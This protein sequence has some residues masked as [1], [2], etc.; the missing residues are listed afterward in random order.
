METSRFLAV[1]ITWNP[2]GWRNNNYINPKAGHVHAKNNVG[3][4]ALNFK[5]NKITI[6]TNKFIYGYVQWTNAP[7]RFENN[8]LI[9]FYTK[10]TDINEGQIVG[11]YGKA[12]IFSKAD[13]HKVPFQQREYWT[14]IKANKDF[15]LLFPIALSADKYKKKS[16]DRIVGQ[17]GFS[18]KNERFA[19]Q[20]LFDELTELLKSGTNENDFNK[21]KTV[22][23]YYIGKKFKF[24][25][26]SNELKEQ[27]EL[28]KYFKKNKSRK[29]II[30]E[31]KNLKETD[32]EEIIINHK[33][34]KRDNKTI[35]QLKIIR[36]FKCQICGVSIPKKDGS[37]YI[38][39][40]HISPKHQKGR[41]C[42]ENII[43]LCPNHHKEYDLGDPKTINHTKEVFEFSLNGNRY[44]LKL[45]LV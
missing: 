7:I 31:L 14:N 4:E 29:E 42:P 3:G 20:I 32:A 10:N 43:L 12:E 22:Y 36:H 17:T 6:D 9:I 19:E 13:S 21:L 38:E 45:S 35:A 25:F 37:K 28:E 39:A 44:K 41:E 16:K 1:N 2:F 23:E 34:Y 18:Y 27:A 26:I 33:T 24:H 40:A 15:A 5:F 30:N 11:I 8:G